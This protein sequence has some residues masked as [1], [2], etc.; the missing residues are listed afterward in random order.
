[1]H[2]KDADGM[3]NSVDIFLQEQSDLGQ[4]CLPRPVCL[5]ILDHYCEKAFGSLFFLEWKQ[6]MLVQI[7]HSCISL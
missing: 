4:H 3:T 1:M 6:Y 5:N 2:P 7:T